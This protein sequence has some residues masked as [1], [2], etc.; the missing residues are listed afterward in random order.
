MQANGQ[1]D[2]NEIDINSDENQSGSTHLNDAVQEEA[3]LEKAKS[4]LEELKKKY[5]LL[6]A[7][8]DNYKK[9][10]A[11]ERIELISTANREVITAL[12]DVLDDTDRASQQ[13]ET[14]GSEAVKDGVSLVFNKLRNILSNKGLKPMESLHQE[15][16]ADLHEAITEIPAPTPDL[17]GKVVDELQKGYY[18]NDKII[19]HARVVVGK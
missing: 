18:L 5:L 7:D 3:E 9:R 4:D 1:P 14:A 19:R 11:K 12:L 8:F 15:F 10:N 2:P 16:D 17:V 13:L 6:S